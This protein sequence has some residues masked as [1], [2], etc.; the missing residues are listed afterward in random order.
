MRLIVI[1]TYVV[2]LSVALAAKLDFDKEYMA[3]MV[4]TS[5]FLYMYIT[6]NF[7]IFLQVNNDDQLAKGDRMRR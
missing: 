7:L 5:P 4:N 3:Q 1:V 2:C 6:G